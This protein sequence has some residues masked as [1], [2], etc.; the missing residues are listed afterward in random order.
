MIV[1]QWEG[2]GRSITCRQEGFLIVMGRL[3]CRKG[4]LEAACY[5][6]PNSG[7]MFSGRSYP[8]V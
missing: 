2:T 8:V 5:M 7:G 1:K 6:Y 3:P 4:K